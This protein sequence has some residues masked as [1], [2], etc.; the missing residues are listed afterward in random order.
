MTALAI[1]SLVVGVIGAG[2]QY[3]ASSAAARSQERIA[4]LNFQASMQS[5]QQQLE[6]ARLQYDTNQKVY[7]QQAAAAR[8]NAEAMRAQAGAQE[9]Q[10]RQNA[11]RTREDYERMK[12]IQRARLAKSGVL[13]AGTPLDLLAETAGQMELA[14]ANQQY[15]SS[16]ETSRTRFMADV[17]EQNA[18]LTEFAGA[19]QGFRDQAALAGARNSM[20]A[21]NIDR[22]VGLNAARQTRQQAAA[23]LLSSG[24]G[25]FSSGYN[26]YQTGAIR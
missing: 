3:F 25:F 5:S 22:L 26:L 20:V 21:A 4:N 23:G 9:T 11:A 16:L 17:E 6:L 18:S 1:G 2:V 14:V 8:N 10:A 7:E 13:E 24:A 15:E 12:A 19:L